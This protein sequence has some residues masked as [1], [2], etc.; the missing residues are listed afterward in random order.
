MNSYEDIKKILF[1]IPDTKPIII[2]GHQNADLD[3]IGSCL[4]LAHFLKLLNKKD[5]TVLISD[6]DMP[7]IEWFKNHNFIRNH[8]EKNNYVFITLDLNRKDRL[9][10]FECYFEKAD[11]TINIDHHEKNKN[12][13]D[14]ILVDTEISSTSEMLYNLFSCFDLKIN[15]E[16]AS[17]LYAGILTDTSCFSQ[18]LTPNTFSITSHL[19]EYN[20]NYT[21]ITKK[22]FLERSMPEIEALQNLLSNIQYDHFHYVIMNRNNPI[23]HDLEYSLLFKKMTPILKNIEGIKVLGMFLI[24]ND[25][26]FGEFK[27]NC[28]ID[29][30]NLAIQLG[31][32][33]HKKAAGFTS[34]LSIDE[35]LSISKKY[36]IEH[37]DF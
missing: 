23:F 1:N 14:Y 15:Y 4:A 20:I 8:I 32:G 30:S 21:E 2:A 13:A 7:K 36:I 19:L 31:G 27:S 22:T 24:D 16:I 5:I 3:S 26:I 10:E 18:R 28:D 29:V 9:G 17:L 11:L 12:E 33:G 6:K 37:S 35:I 34:N 25:I